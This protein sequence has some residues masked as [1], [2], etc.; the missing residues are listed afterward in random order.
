MDRHYL[1]LDANSLKKENW[2]LTEEAVFKSAIQGFRKIEVEVR[3]PRNYQTDDLQSQVN[4]IISEIGVDKN[5]FEVKVSVRFNLEEEV[6]KVTNEMKT[7]F[8]LKQITSDHRSIK[9]GGYYYRVVGYFPALIEL[10]QHNK[11]HVMYMESL[12][13]ISL[14]RLMLKD[15][16]EIKCCEVLDQLYM[17][18]QLAINKGEKYLLLDN[19]DENF[20]APFHSQCLKILEPELAKLSLGY[21]VVEVSYGLY[22]LVH[23]LVWNF[24]RC[25]HRLYE[26]DVPQY[27]H[28]AFNKDRYLDAKN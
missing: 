23:L 2:S 27:L 20:E 21:K 22:D 25:C 8:D 11:Y 6:N 12:A 3:V 14:R 1:H 17:K 9:G 18:A 26:G 28:R 15:S 13:R 19:P 10:L 5:I 24:D 4:Q 16:L 7:S